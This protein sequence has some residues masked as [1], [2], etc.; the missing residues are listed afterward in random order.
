MKI[1]DKLLSTR[2]RA[3]PPIPCRPAAE[4]RREAADVFNFGL[5]TFQ[6]FSMVTKPR[7]IK[8]LYEFRPFRLDPHRRLLLRGND[9]VPLTPKAV[10]TLVVLVENR[11]HVV[12]KD[13]LMA[14]LWPNSF[15]EESNLTQ[16]VF[17]LRKALG[18]SAQERRYIL[19][20]PGRGYQFTEAV[21]DLGESPLVDETLVLESHSRSQIFVA[22]SPPR[23]PQLRIRPLLAIL[24]LGM[25][26]SGVLFYRD[27]HRQPAQQAVL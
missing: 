18:D 14:M 19:N 26:A 2:G 20:V 5:K 17:V 7:P 8:H 13:D 9:T 15:V 12:S 22:P 4:C 16:N 24:A 21:R 10:E 1:G 23:T 3:P 11:D 6:S 27:Q 25:I